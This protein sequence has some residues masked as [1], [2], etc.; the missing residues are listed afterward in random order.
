MQFKLDENLPASLVALFTDA[1][2]DAVSTVAQDLQGEPDA[3]IA[4][5]CRDEQRA[6]VTLDV[7]FGDIRAYPPQEYPGIIV[8]R[9]K[10][11]DVPH[12][13]VTIA[14]VLR[15]VKERPVVKTLW[16]V[17]HDRVRYRR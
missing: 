15:L 14:R 13:K 3:T 8:L 11:Q 7:G 17:E 16:I 5:V 10:H 2:H 1:G 4:A 9:S 12:L 6:L